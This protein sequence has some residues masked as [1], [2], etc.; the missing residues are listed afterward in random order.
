[1]TTYF[2]SK[3]IHIF[4]SVSRRAYLPAVVISISEPSKAQ[5]GYDEKYVELKQ[6]VLK[7]CPAS[8]H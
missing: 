1:M 5:I 2:H 6:V 3:N 7:F 4:T 8:V